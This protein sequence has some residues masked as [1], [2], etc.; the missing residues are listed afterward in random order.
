LKPPLST[1]SGEKCQRLIVLSGPMT[2]AHATQIAE[3]V[4]KN[5]LPMMSI[6]TV[7]GLNPVPL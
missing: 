2:N 6:G 5:G 1:I 4:R 3:L 7:A